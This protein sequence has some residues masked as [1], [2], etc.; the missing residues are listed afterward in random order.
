MDFDPRTPVVVRCGPLPIGMRLHSELHSGMV[1]ISAVL[2]DVTQKRVDRPVSTVPNSVDVDVN[3]VLRLDR[4]AQLGSDLFLREEVVTGVD[5]GAFVVGGPLMGAWT[6]LGMLPSVCSPRP[7]LL[8][9]S[10]S[11]WLHQPLL[12]WRPWA[13]LLVVSPLEWHHRPLLGWRPQLLLGWRP[14]L[15]WLGVSPSE[16]HPRPLLGWHPRPLLG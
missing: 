13:T 12:G 1:K 6:L 14:W 11:E 3:G 16:W 2:V 7:F 10:P 8:V 5:C 9:V 15:T 4:Q